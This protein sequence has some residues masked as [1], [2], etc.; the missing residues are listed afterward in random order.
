MLYSVD[1]ATMN[2]HWHTRM[3]SI[4]ILNEF[5]LLLEKAEKHKQIKLSEEVYTKVHNRILTSIYTASFDTN[6]HVKNI[7]SQVRLI[8]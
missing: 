1:N 3:S 6:D 2:A 4:A 5:R 7:A 8:N